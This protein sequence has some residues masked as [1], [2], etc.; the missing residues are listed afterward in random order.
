MKLDRPHIRCN[1]ATQTDL[2]TYTVLAHT[3][4]PIQKRLSLKFRHTETMRL[5]ALLFACFSS[6]VLKPFFCHLVSHLTSC[7]YSPGS[8]ALS[9]PRTAIWST[10]YVRLRCT[11]FKLSRYEQITIKMNPYC[12]L[13]NWAPPTTKKGGALC[14]GPRGVQVRNDFLMLAIEL[15]QKPSNNILC[16]LDLPTSFV[17][18]EIKIIEWARNFNSLVIYFSGRIHGRRV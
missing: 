9:G 14:S 4:Q 13:E 10:F 18:S 6:S 12:M 7:L 15:H 16:V 8:Y 5:K 1:I 2:K 11:D 17:D 3:F